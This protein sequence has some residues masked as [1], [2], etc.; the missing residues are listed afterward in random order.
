MQGIPA[1]VGGVIAGLRNTLENST[2][3]GTARRAPLPEKSAQF[4]R[5]PAHE[6]DTSLDLRD[7]DIFVR[8]MRLADR[9]GTADDRLHIGQLKMARLGRVRHGD[10]EEI[11][12]PGPIVIVARNGMIQQECSDARTTKF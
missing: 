4:L 1:A 8:L 11:D 3:T 7:L 9:A 5:E 10:R 2:G 6:G 12:S